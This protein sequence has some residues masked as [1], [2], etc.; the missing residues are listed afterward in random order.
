MTL[1]TPFIYIIGELVFFDK[2]REKEEFSN[3]K[4]RLLEYADNWETE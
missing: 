1:C 2:I 4:K 3:I